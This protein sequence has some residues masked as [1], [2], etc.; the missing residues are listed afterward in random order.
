MTVRMTGCREIAEDSDAVQRLRDLY[1]AVEKGSTPVS[2]LFPWLPSRARK[3]KREATMG[4]YMMIVQH[5]ITRRAEKREENDAMQHL[6]DEGDSDAQIVEVSLTR[7][8][9]DCLLT[10]WKQFIMI[11][12]FAGIRKWALMDAFNAKRSACSF[13]RNCVLVDRSIPLCV[14]GMEN[15]STR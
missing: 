2:V 11:S 6:M 4:L 3:A 15:Q 8:P 7:S 5:I 9:C 13:H 10:C 14:P 12:L 1:W